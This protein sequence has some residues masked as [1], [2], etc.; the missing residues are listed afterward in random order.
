MT[1]QDL[2]NLI[3]FIE[4]KDYTVMWNDGYDKYIILKEEV[5]KHDDELKVYFE[6]FGVK[7]IDLY[8]CNHDDFLVF[9]KGMP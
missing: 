2:K 6:N 8:G 3:E 7:Y 9:Y 4:S 5:Y 1:E